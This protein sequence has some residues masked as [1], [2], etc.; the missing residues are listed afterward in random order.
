L[1]A[2]LLA[3]ACLAQEPSFRVPSRLVTAPT[4]V[5]SRDDRLIFGLER[6][7]FRVFDNGR[8]QRAA[9]DTDAAPISLVVAVQANQ[10]MRHYLRF[11]A[12]VGSTVEALLVGANGE[13]AV[14]TYGADIKVIKP[15]GSGDVQ[16]ALRTVTGAGRHA[17]A[18]DAGMHAISL[19]KD[20]SRRR[21]KVLLY[22]G[23]AMDSGSESKIM[24][25][26]D[27]AERENVSVY[28]LVLPEVGKAFVSD[29]F[30]L[31]G[32]SSRS[33]RGGFKAGVD[34]GRLG[35]VLSHAA[36][37]SQATD[38]FSILTSATGGTQFHF[39]EQRE[40]ENGIALVGVELR[41]AYVLSY[42]PDSSE[43]GY[44]TIRV[45]VGVP[46]A[47]VHS[48]PGYWMK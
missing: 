35:P 37:V 22:V 24:A 33:D 20:R 3:S 15:F 32:L 18:I 38:P 45:D 14:L 1:V 7:D 46:G 29:T 47:K 8:A 5:F 43:Q 9:L 40:L 48:R 11:I 23:Q 17:R 31:D 13:A 42:A 12:R 2:A 27:E 26:R 44:H 30:S 6:N 21:G 4:L 10:D 25:L 39:R 19:L 28:A 36:E 16:L 41:S 34:L